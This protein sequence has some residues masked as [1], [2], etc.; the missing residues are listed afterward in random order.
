MLD[1]IRQSASSWG[2]KILFGIIILVFVFWGV[3]SF[4]GSKTQVIATVNE[5]PI[6][7]QTFHR[8]QQRAVE[9]MQQRNPEM[10]MEELKAMGLN[11]QVLESLVAEELMAEKAAALGITVSDVELRQKINE[12]PYFQNESGQFDPD[13]YR[14]ILGSQQIPIAEFEEDMRRSIVSEK[15]EGYVTYPAQA[16]ADEARELFEYSREKRT[17]QYLM[18]DAARLM[19]QV[20]ATKEEIASFYEEHKEDFSVPLRLSFTYL[21]FTASSLA[22]KVDVPDDYLREEYEARKDEFLQPERVEARHILIEVED[23]AD[24]AAVEQA[25]REIETARMR[26][27]DAGEDFAT[28]AMEVSEGP[29][30]VSGGDLGWFSRGQMV[31]SF[32]EVAFSLEP[33]AVS[34]PVRTPFGY[35]I[36]LVEEREDEQTTPF[37]EIKDDL[38][39]G[40]AEDRAADL[41][42]NLLDVALEQVYAGQSLESVASD[43][44]LELQSTQAPQTRDETQMLLALEDEAVDRLFSME[45]GQV[46]DTPL[47]STEGYVLATVQERLP[48]D[49]KPLEEVREAIV[50]RIKQDKV[51]KL[52]KARA[53]ELA[54][55]V[56][57][58]GVPA[59]KTDDLLTTNSFDRQGLIEGLGM[60][61]ELTQ[62]AF[63]AEQGDWLPGAW[64]VQD[65]YIVANLHEVIPATDA[66][67]ATEKSM[68]MDFISESKK[69]ELFRAFLSDMQEKAEILVYQPK[70]LE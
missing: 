8:A 39:Q 41:I 60:N 50:E 46:T 62:K 43:L 16:S 58:S 53:E 17:L 18:V 44:N 61:Q 3:G 48:P 56:Q 66:Q 25:K 45:E 10:S 35:H 47:E 36:I 55:Q 15:L 67:W 27:V 40:I 32:E 52:A 7:V 26:I 14:R 51:K 13:L 6:L 33:G 28:V 12:L 19:D 23:D 29:S 31:P 63:A 68:W 5:R 42:S 11:R 70:L 64:A 54:A 22:S 2:V 20:N 24:E 57:E 34:E 9:N 59:D 1:A 21:P 37:E 4:T 38:R 30:S 49:Y 65:G 69:E